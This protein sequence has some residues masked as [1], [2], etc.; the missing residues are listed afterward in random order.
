MVENSLSSESIS[1]NLDTCYIGR[2]I[3][4]YP[5]LTSTMEVARK[6]ARR[7]AV[8]GTVVIADEQTVGKGR[9]Q[10]AWITTRGNIALSL[11]LRPQ[12]SHLSYMVMIASLSV[13]N[14]IEAV[15]GLKVQIKWPNDV[16]INGK[17]VCGILIENDIRG[18]KVAY[19]IIGIGINVLI[20]SDEYPDLLSSATSLSGESGT[21]VSRVDVICRLLKETEELYDKLPA[22]AS[23][24]QEWRDRLTMLGE[25]VKIISGDNLVEGFAESVNRDGSLLLRYPDGSSTKI[26]AGDVTLCV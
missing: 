2:R 12:I 20:N 10:R 3:I 23:I 18:D 21:G 26:I 5:S 16:L 4:Y 24:Y 14:S 7:G 11:I 8:E 25:N 17:K 6:E 13:A 15:T 19:S 9:K 22:G 1:R